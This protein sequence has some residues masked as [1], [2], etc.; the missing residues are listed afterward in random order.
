MEG[1][2]HGVFTARHYRHDPVTGEREKRPYKV[3]RVRNSFVNA[4][5]A[6][7][8]NLIAGAGGQA[9]D[10]THAYIGAGDSNTATTSGMTDLQATLAATVNIA[11]STNASPIVLT[12]SGAHGYAAGDTITV[13][14]HT[15]NT[16][17]NGTW[18]ITV[19]SGTTI[20]LVGSTGSGVGGADRKS[21]V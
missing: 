16:V 2:R 5:G 14:G 6:L 4:G 3:V 12:T 15:T 10:N 18:V 7:L 19:P 8:V 9:F 21:V 17:A 11:S 13:A 20:G 1:L